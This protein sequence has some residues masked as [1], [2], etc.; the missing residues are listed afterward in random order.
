MMIWTAIKLMT[1]WFKWWGKNYYKNYVNKKQIV[2]NV[3]SA[4]ERK[5]FLPT[6]MQFLPMIQLSVPV[7]TMKLLLKFNEMKIQHA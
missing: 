2:M 1:M 7:L 6:A 5:F 4:K 3:V